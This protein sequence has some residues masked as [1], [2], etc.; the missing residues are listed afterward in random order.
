[1]YKDRFNR[2]IKYEK[3]ENSSN[4]YFLDDPPSIF[5]LIFFSD[6]KSRCQHIT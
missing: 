4:Q 5:D 2:D 6:G 3:N 1:M